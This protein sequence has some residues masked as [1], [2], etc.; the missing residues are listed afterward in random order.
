MRY[1]VFFAMLVACLGLMAPC[2]GDDVDTTVKVVVV[3]G[4]GAAKDDAIADGE[5]QAVRQCL[6]LLCKT[7][8]LA[9]NADVL[10]THVFAQVSQYTDS[11]VQTQETNGD[12]RCVV[13]LSV[14]VHLDKLEQSMDDLWEKLK[15][16]GNPRIII[17]IE[18]KAPEDT[19][20][21][22]AQDTLTAKLV[23]LGFKVLDETQLKT[24]DQ[25]NALKLV[26]DGHED[27]ATIMALQDVSDML[28]VGKAKATEQPT[29][30]QGAFSAQGTFDAKAIATDTA[31]VLAAKR[32]KSTKAGFTLVSAAESSLEAA[33]DD[34]AAK[35]LSN[36]VRA[37]VDPCK[38]YNI[39]YT[40]CEEKDIVAL[41]N[42][43]APSLKVRK[44]DQVAF[45]K[46]VA[47]LAV[48]YQD[49]L[50]K[51]AAALS[52]IDGIEVEGTEHC[53]VRIHK[54]KG[55]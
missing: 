8:V 14:Q 26:R 24:V 35:N 30:V 4:T 49:S 25:R 27:A 6:S 47:Q 46:G 39:I 22:L 17:T 23:D 48:Q 32:G 18:Q 10:Q 53:T 28:I 16:A 11:T 2:W 34:W 54:K 13:K 15:V 21:S 19:T 55:W 7:E 20:D 31:Q 50:T 33:S 3:Q 40:G 45:D 51:L 43:L 1:V 37:I 36:V 42:A 9:A 41:D 44:L 5:Q 12:G 52:G 38:E 29:D